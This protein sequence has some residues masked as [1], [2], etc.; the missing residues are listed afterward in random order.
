MV[1][2][3]KSTTSYERDETESRAKPAYFTASTGKRGLLTL[4]TNRFLVRI[5]EPYRYASC[6]D[7]VE[8]FKR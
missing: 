4:L 6:N 5:I 1:P 2:D 8:P 7:R 3:L